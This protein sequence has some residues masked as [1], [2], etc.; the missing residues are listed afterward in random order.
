[1]KHRN[2]IFTAILLALAYF[3]LCPNALLPVAQARQPT[4]D[5]GNGNSAAEGVQ[6]LNLSTT[7][8]NNTAHGWFSLFSNMS[9][10]F[11]TADG[12]Q[13]LYSN[14]IGDDNTANGGAALYNNIDGLGNT[15]DGGAA[16]YNNTTGRFNTAVGA[17]ALYG[18][19]AGS[20]NTAVGAGAGANVTGSRNVAIG[21]FGAL[22]EGGVDD[23]TW[24]ANVYS[25]VATGRAVYINS[26]NKIGTLSSTRRVKEDIRPMN[27]ASEV[28]LALKPVTFRYK[29]E[30]DP[31]RSPQFG[32]I[33]EQVA[34]I[35]PALVT[36]NTEGK[37]ETVR[38][39]AV[40]AMLLNEF[41]KEHRKVQEQEAAIVQLKKQF[42]KVSAQQRQEI[43]ILTAQLK[44]QA[45]QIRKVSVQIEA[46]KVVT[47]RVRHG[48]PARQLASNDY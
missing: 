30:I 40:N 11:N 42:R 21:S 24:I 29:K 5:R 10:L 22:G 20:F 35:D 43:E 37:P 28:V 23:T 4:E 26:D 7:G 25:S 14:T 46:T 9:G 6:A 34:E 15:A 39:D 32:L 36:R 16:L 18:N 48:G 12:F 38:Y 8:S 1:M 47:R 45:A 27:E 41:L 13:A 44:E 19:A 17:Q 3:A 33:A 2:I 31:T